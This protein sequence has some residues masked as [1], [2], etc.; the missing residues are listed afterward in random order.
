MVE[1]IFHCPVSV[2]LTGTVESLPLSLLQHFRSNENSLSLCHS[3]HLSDGRCQTMASAI[4]KQ[5]IQPEIRERLPS[6]VPPPPSPYI[7]LSLYNNSHGS[8]SSFILSLPGFWRK[9]TLISYSPPAPK[10]AARDAFDGT[11][12][13]REERE[14]IHVYTI[15]TGDKRGG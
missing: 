4:T 6:L 8:V 14:D 11:R 1:V 2:S 13:R 9:Q 5:S 10:I 12:G 3:F 7:L 15:G